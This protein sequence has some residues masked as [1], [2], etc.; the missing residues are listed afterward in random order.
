MVMR[1]IQRVAL[2]FTLAIVMSPALLTKYLDA[3]KEVSR[4][5]VLLPDGIRFSP[6]SSRRSQSNFSSAFCRNMDSGFLDGTAL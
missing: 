3:A 1:L 6:S 4:H 2:V 5:A